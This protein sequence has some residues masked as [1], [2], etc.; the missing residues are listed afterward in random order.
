MN[1]DQ[2]GF[3]P[4]ANGFGQ[5]P[6]DSGQNQQSQNNFG[7]NGTEQN[8]TQNQNGAEQNP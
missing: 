4:N 1:G 5:N 2:N 8:H 3:E 7:T 6:A